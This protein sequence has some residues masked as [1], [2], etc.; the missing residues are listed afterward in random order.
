MKDDGGED[1]VDRSSESVELL[2]RVGNEPNEPSDESNLMSQA[3]EAFPLG[4]SPE[5]L[6]K[7]TEQRY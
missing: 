3:S 7:G 4:L 2:S 1:E 5:S 6:T